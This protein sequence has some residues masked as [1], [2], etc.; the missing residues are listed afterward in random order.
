MRIA[1]SK[2]GRLAIVA[3]G[4][5]IAGGLTGPA[6]ASVVRPSASLPLIGVPYISPTGAGCFNAGVCVTPGPFVQ[7][8]A[9]SDSSRR[10]PPAVQEII[11]DADYGATLTLPPP[12]PDTP[13]GSVAL[14]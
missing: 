11:A 5:A 3:V 6:T 7:T 14:H 12:A 9:T 4:L 2:H 1:I 13:I 10:L 8:S